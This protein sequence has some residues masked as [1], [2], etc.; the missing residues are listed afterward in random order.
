MLQSAYYKINKMEGIKMNVNKY[1]ESLNFE[2]EK[3]S[4]YYVDYLKGKGVKNRR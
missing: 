4:R 1:I 2:K 3:D